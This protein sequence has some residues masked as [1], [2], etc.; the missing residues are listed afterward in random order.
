M[1][2]KAT[3]LGIVLL[4]IVVIILGTIIAFYLSSPDE[5]TA[6]E[7]ISLQE[8]LSITELKLCD[9]IDENYNCNQRSNTDF[10]VGDKALIYFKIT[11]FEKEQKGDKA[12][13]RLIE[14]FRLLDSNGEVVPT[15]DMPNLV[16][17]NQ[18]ISPNL[19]SIPV[20]NQIDLM[21]LR[22]DDLTMEISIKDLVAG[23]TVIARKTIR[24]SY[25]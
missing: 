20:R 2:K 7:E 9:S 13:V 17:I 12:N 8:E 10:K 15:F 5:K 4:A 14:D 3:H 1:N 18:E 16:E 23:E 6:K 25:G 11:G 21:I 24:L 22:S 19:A